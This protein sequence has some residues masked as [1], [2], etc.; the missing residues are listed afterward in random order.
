[1]HVIGLRRI[2]GKGVKGVFCEGEV[3]FGQREGGGCVDKVGVLGFEVLAY[4]ATCIG[5]I[6]MYVSS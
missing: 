3:G 4:E 1:M 2:D 5:E 6:E